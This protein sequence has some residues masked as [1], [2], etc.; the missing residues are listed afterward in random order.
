MVLVGELKYSGTVEKIKLG[1][2]FCL[3][4]FGV[5]LN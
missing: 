4:S 5:F 1:G 2:L 3:L